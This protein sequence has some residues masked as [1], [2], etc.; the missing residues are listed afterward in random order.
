M[1]L[2]H[3]DNKIVPAIASL[4]F[5]KHMKINANHVYIHVSF[6]LTQLLA[7]VAKETIEN[8]ILIQIVN[9]KTDSMMMEYQAV[10]HAIIDALLAQMLAHAILA[11]LTELNMWTV[12]I[13]N[14]MKIALELTMMVF[15]HARNFIHM[16]MLMM[17]NAIIATQVALHAVIAKH[18][19]NVA[20][21]EQNA[22][23]IIQANAAALMALMIYTLQRLN[24]KIAHSLAPHVP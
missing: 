2:L 7:Q 10:N 5:M 17:K 22:I 24:V 12:A 8:L 13:L 21:Q 6:V 9:A 11:N 23:R 18:V 15:A 19:I 16:K 14:L 3:P 1:I 4:A 20:I